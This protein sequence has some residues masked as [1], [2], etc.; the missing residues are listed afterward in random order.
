MN[1]KLFKRENSLDELLDFY[2]IL[3]NIKTI[4]D[5]YDLKLKTLQTLF[6]DLVILIRDDI[7]KNYKFKNRYYNSKN[8]NKSKLRELYLLCNAFVMHPTKFSLDDLIHIIE[9]TRKTIKQVIKE[10]DYDLYINQI[11]EKVDN[12]YE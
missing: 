2:D 7:N 9:K 6:K 8:N 10:E 4:D 5:Y 3:I 1:I 11:Q 12:Y